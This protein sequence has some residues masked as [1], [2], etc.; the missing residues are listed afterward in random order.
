MFRIEC[1]EEELES[2]IKDEEDEEGVF[3]VRSW[4]R[5]GKGIE[6]DGKH[7]KLNEG[8]ETLFTHNEVCFG[9][10]RFSPLLFCKIV[11]ENDE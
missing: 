5:L 4:F 8:K 2:R 1:D 7:Y 9:S 3:P 10:T 6:E 11:E